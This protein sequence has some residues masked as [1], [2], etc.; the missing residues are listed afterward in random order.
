MRQADTRQLTLVTCVGCWVKEGVVALGTRSREN[1]FI[2]GMKR[3]FREEEM[4]QLRT[5]R[6]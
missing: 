2:P 6:H 3:D 1:S 5:I 4:A